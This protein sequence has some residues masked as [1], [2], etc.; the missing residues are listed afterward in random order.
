M[1][2]IEITEVYWQAGN[3]GYAIPSYGVVLTDTPKGPEAANLVEPGQRISTGKELLAK[4]IAAITDSGQG[5]WSTNI[6]YSVTPM[7]VMVEV[8]LNN[9]RI[10]TPSRRL[11]LLKGLGIVLDEKEQ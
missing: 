10:G 7:E 8:I 9:P 11:E 2:K 6:R 3:G 1:A 5:G 4:A